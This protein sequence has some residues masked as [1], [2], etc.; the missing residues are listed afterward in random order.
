MA[1]ID[2]STATRR[3]WAAEAD[4][5][6]PVD[7]ANVVIS[8][9]SAVVAVASAI[10]SGLAWLRSRDARDEAEKQR[11][12]AVAASIKA[13]SAIDRIAA[14]QESQLT[15]E[16]SAQAFSVVIVPAENWQD[17]VGWHVLNDSDQPVTQVGVRSAT[18]AK[19]KTYN[20]DLTEYDEYVEPTLARQ[21]RSQLSF[22]PTDGEGPKGRPEEIETMVLRFT[23]AR[24]Q[25]WERVGSQPPQRLNPSTHD[26]AI[27]H[28]YC[29]R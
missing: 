21:A 18:G 16:E 20:N 15:I 9:I 23:D 6:W 3:R 13:A 22:R 11:N 17:R 7:L 28:V 25:T 2:A 4:G 14:V 26:R 29:T 24:R 1:E 27:L 8:G 5:L 19:I 12:Q 10:A